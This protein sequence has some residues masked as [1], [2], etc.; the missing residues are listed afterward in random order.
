[1]K[2]IYSLLIAGLLVTCALGQSPQGRPSFTGA[3]FGERGPDGDGSVEVSGELKQWH[4]VTLKHWKPHLR[5]W[6]TGDPSWKDGKGKGMIGAINYLSGKGCNVFS[7]LPYN[8]GGDGDNVWPFIA[9]ND[10]FHYD[11]SKLPQNDLLCEDWRSRDRSWDYCRFA[12]DF[13]RDEKIPFWEMSNADGLVG[14]PG[15]DNS[16]YCFA[17]KGEIYLVYLPG[18]G[19]RELDLSGTTGEFQVG[20]FD[21]RTGGELTKVAPGKGGAAMK[22]EAP[23]AENDWLAVVRQ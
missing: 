2:R 13:F 5:D 20:W 7:F 23:D 9:R 14:N 16:A 8:A 15:H 10:K 11:C 22:L 6:K 12:L 17:R 4:K 18:G 3:R 21:P 19:R 1:M